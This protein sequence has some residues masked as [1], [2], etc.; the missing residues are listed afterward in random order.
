MW[1]WG[2]M[3]LETE[4]VFCVPPCVKQI[5]IQILPYL[6]QGKPTL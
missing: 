3:N 4:V 1:T 5:Q 6:K 2:G